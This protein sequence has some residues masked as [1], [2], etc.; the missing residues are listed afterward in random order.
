M[1]ARSAILAVLLSGA[2]GVSLV[3]LGWAADPGAPPPGGAVPPLGETTGT[4]TAIDLT[5]ETVTLGTPRGGR[6]LRFSRRTTV[7]ARG[8]SAPLTELAVGQPVHVMFE[9]GPEPPL[10]EWIESLTE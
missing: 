4:I 2:S 7:F 3:V 1:S 10:L 9:P 8:R 5:Q 6:R